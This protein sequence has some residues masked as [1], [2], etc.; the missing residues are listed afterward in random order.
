MLLHSMGYGPYIFT[1][2]NNSGTEP[3]KNNLIYDDRGNLLIKKMN[4]LEAG[5][6]FLFIYNQNKSYTYVFLLK[7]KK[8]YLIEFYKLI[9]S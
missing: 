3:D 8:P 5:G 1:I 9:K 7:M 4:D 2:D 6:D